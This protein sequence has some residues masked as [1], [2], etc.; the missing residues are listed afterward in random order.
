MERE[1]VG[2]LSIQVKCSLPFQSNVCFQNVICA[3]L[4]DSCILN[5][6]AGSLE[7]ASMKLRKYA[8]SGSLVCNISQMSTTQVTSLCAIPP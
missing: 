5:A 1:V 7:I 4:I 3:G 2:F 6:Y 8:E